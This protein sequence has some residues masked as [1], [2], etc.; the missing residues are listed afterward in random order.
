MRVLNGP[1]GYGAVTKVL[2]WVTVLA[3]AAQFAVGIT[4]EAD[5]EAS[6]REDARIDAVEE[7]GEDAEERGEDAGEEDGE[8][9]FDAHLDRLE[10]EL[11]T[12]EEEY[13]A[14]AFADL[15]TG[16]P[17]D[18]LTLPEVHVLL[19]AGLI[20]LGLFRVLW[21]AT[22]PLPP[23]AAHL[24]AQERVLETVLEKVMLL[25]LFLV[26]ATGLLLVATSVD[27]LWV[28]LAAQ[29][30]FLAAIGVHVGLVLRHTVIR[31]EGELRRML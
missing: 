5:D 20:V 16:G 29:A 3:V 9:A 15:F 25:S 27:W 2:H 23:W 12:R 4:M 11:D 22:T 17:R 13:V 14:T 10:D 30:G 7:R 21:R 6:D 19:G 28:H 1:V 31:R 8:E 26:P 24:S 18:G